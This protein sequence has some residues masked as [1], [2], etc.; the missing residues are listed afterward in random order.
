MSRID[1]HFAK[2][3]LLLF[4]REWY[5]HPSGAM[6]AYEW[7]LRDVNP[8]VHAW[9]C[10]RVYKI[11]GVAGKRD[12]GFL[13][14]AFQKLLINF[15]WWVNRKDVQGK[16]IFAGGFLGS[17]TSGS[18]TARSRCPRASRSLRPTARRGWPSIAVPCFPL[19]S[20]WRA[21]IPLTRTSRRNSR[22]HGR[23]RGRDERRGRRRLWDETDGF[24]YDQLLIEGRR[25]VP[26]RVR[27]LVGLLPLFA[28]EILDQNTIDQ[29]P[30][31][32]R[33]LKWFVKYRFDL[34]QNISYRKTHTADARACA[35]S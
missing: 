19:R 14:R 4:L 13:E 29:L 1:P 18:S 8:P 10:W 6:P 3:Q 31:F 16:H 33:R 5:M 30:G 2:Q 21:P 20:S 35:G 7:N 15:T 32:S 17:I 23:D 24:Y 22:A 34:A 12:T 26:L 27:S 28:V 9:A 11:S 25:T